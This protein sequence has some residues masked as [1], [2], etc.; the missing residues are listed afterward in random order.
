MR[1]LLIQTAERMRC[2]KHISGSSGCCN[3]LK[4]HSK[5]LG[6]N[7]FNLRY[8]ACASAI[9]GYSVIGFQRER[10]VSSSSEDIE[11]F[12]DCLSKRDACEL[13]QRAFL[14]GF[15]TCQ[16]RMCRMPS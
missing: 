10:S 6:G 2:L 7:E 12:Y 3:E 1:E 14:E 8:C 5:T 16:R 4:T 15:C 11:K 13:H 9:P